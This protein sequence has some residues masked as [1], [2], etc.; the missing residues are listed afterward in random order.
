M[1]LL[2]MPI[3]ACT[4]NNE[5]SMRNADKGF[6]VQ[7]SEEDWKAE[8]SKEEYHILREA[9]TER[10]GSG[11]YVEVDTDG[12]FRCAGCGNELFDSKTKF[13]SGTGWPSFYKPYDESNVVNRSDN[14]LGTTRTEVLCGKCGGHLGHVFDD[15]P[16]PT[17]KRYCINSAALDLKER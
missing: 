6:E 1:L 10:P 16:E 12:I 11:K 13:K 8:L 4:Q 2:Q 17:G 3:T 14:S 5:R 15:G 7:K 9:G